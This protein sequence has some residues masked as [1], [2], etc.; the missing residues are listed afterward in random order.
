MKKCKVSHVISDL[1][2]SE[3]IIALTIEGYLQ[4]ESKDVVMRVNHSCASDAERLT[5]ALNAAKESSDD[6]FFG[7]TE[8]NGIFIGSI[9][10]GIG[11]ES[12]I[13]DGLRKTLV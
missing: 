5:K 13:Y 10:L 7:I 4:N 6:I 11:E 1:S 9:Q 2:G 8:A 12:F 3:L